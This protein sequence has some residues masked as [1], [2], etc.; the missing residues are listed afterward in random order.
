MDFDTFLEAAWNDHGDRPGEVAE[1]LAASLQIIQSPAHIPPFAALV[2]HVYG[3]H[4]GRF[5]DG[6]RLLESLRGL[7]AFDGAPDAIARLDRNIATLRVAGGD[8]DTL[9]TLTVDDRAA[10]LASVASALAGRNE[11]ARAI[12]AY[13]EA[14]ALAGA[15]IDASSPAI[16]ALAVGGNNLAAALEQKQDRDPAETLAMV[17]AAE[18]ALAHWKIAGTWLEEER[19]EY[20]LA[21]SQ[22]QA[23]NATAAVDRAHRC[24]EICD[25]NDAP[26]FER[27]FAHAVAA[28]AQRAAGAAAA[29][30]A[31]RNR[32]LAL[33]E[34]MPKEDRN[35][36]EADL[37]ELRG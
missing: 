4:L 9:A 15:G 25:R 26:A 22:L 24:I 8:A 20:R 12:S 29:S 18:S 37:R 27:F 6:I 1:R 33:F 34:Q 17:A 10:V 5:D 30:D 11:F 35:A 14:M 2:T 36:C 21:R 7:P 31:S 3:E 23:G 28:L 19:A 13:R 32:A 16:R